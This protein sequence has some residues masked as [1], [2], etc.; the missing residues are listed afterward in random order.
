M[1]GYDVKGENLS[2][3]M[4]EATLDSTENENIRKMALGM[5]K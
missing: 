4:A 3:F 2:T 5:S 1:T